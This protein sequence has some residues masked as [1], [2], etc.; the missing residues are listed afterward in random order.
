[1]IIKKLKFFNFYIYKRQRLSEEVI[2]IDFDSYFCDDI[3]LYV[4]YTD[5]NFEYNFVSLSEK[6]DWSMLALWTYR[7]SVF[8]LLITKSIQLVCFKDEK[9]YFNR[10]R[11]REYQSFYFKVI[12]NTC[13]GNDKFCSEILNFIT[14]ANNE[15]NKEVELSDYLRLINDK[16]LGKDGEYNRPEKRFIIELVKQYAKDYK[17]INIISE[18]KMLG[19]YK[20]HKIELNK[21][22]IPRLKIHHKELENYYNDCINEHYTLRQLASKIREDLQDDFE[23]RHPKNDDVD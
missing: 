19:L 20:H 22:Y 9:S 11:K 12:N 15:L 1:M 4:I 17:W 10:L 13:Q 23:N 6:K 14:K 18:K 5:P 21:I 3:G 2:D 8:N 7:L 16:Y